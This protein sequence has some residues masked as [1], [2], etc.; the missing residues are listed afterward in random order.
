MRQTLEVKGING[1]GAIGTP[2]LEFPIGLE[3]FKIIMTNNSGSPSAVTTLTNFQ[4]NVNGE[5]VMPLN[6]QDIDEINKVDGL[7]PY[8]ANSIL[9]LDF[10]NQKFIDGGPHQAPSLNTGVP[11]PK[12][13][14]II[15][16]LQLQWQQSGAD[17]WTIK[18]VCG[19]PDPVGPGTIKRFQ[20][21]NDSF[22]SGES[23]TT[24]IQYGTA[25]QA[26]QRR[27]FLKASSGTI[28]QV[29]LLQGL[30]NKEVFKR[31][32]DENNQ[33]LADQ[34]KTPGTYFG[35]VLDW[36]ENNMPDY[37]NTLT[38]D[39]VNPSTGI[40]IAKSYQLLTTNG[41][42]ATGTYIV[43]CLGAIN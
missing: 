34:G 14:K 38:S 13:G 36:T 15:S 35:Y 21:F 33:I 42:A 7:T 12:T 16:S 40:A 23:G 8:A 39:F 1:N 17:S 3:I 9:E 27:V 11:D 29:R 43:E 6:G 32:T 25:K 30:Q 22:V 2:S 20:K 41:A 10:E 24:Q 37:L 5:N 19:L 4:L 28:S 31:T 26:L 18:V